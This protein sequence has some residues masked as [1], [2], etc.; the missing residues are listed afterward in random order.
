MNNH[1]EFHFVQWSARP[2]S[3][4]RRGYVQSVSEIR[5][6][7]LADSVVVPS[8]RMTKTPGLIEITDHVLP[9]S[10]V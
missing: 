6:A 1:A 8:K 10:L 5:R 3:E 9:L 2:V 4:S 7:Y